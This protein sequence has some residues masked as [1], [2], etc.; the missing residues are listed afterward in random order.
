MHPKPRTP[1]GVSGDVT[2][3]CTRDLHRS[4]G[5]TLYL[6][7]WG[8]PRPAVRNRGSTAIEKLVCERK[9]SHFQT[10]CRGR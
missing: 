5:T 6:A 9:A 1:A 8:V 4:I 7:L 3:E 2:T 10:R